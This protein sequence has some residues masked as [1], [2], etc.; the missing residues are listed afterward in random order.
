LTVLGR[1]S[2]NTDAAVC[3]WIKVFVA[4]QRFDYGESTSG[5]A[6]CFFAERG[7]KTSLSNACRDEAPCYRRCVTR[8]YENTAAISQQS[9]HVERLLAT[10][11]DGALEVVSEGLAG[12]DAGEKLAIELMHYGEKRFIGTQTH[13]SMQLALYGD[14][15]SRCCMAYQGLVSNQLLDVLCH[16]RL[17]DIGFS[18]PKRQF[19]GSA[20][21]MLLR[22]LRVGRV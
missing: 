20:E 8:A 11:K 1:E 13:A 15:I 10:S 3:V 6:E 7:F 4:L 16:S 2:V 5:E 17:F 9:F 21:E 18:S 19:C 12:A 14:P 22:H